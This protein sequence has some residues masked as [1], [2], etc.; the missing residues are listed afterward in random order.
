MAPLY[1]DFGD[2]RGDDFRAWWGGTAQ[3]GAALFAENRL[4]LSVKKIDA[5]SDWDSRWGSN[6]LVVALNMELGRRKLQSYL[7]KMLET[8]HTGKRGRKAMGKVEST[9]QFPLTRNFSVYNLK[10]MLMVYDTVAANETRPKSERK[11]LWKIG[12]E[13]KL[14]PSSM[15]HREDN[16]YDTRM[17]HNTLSMTV[18]RYANTARLIIANTAK[19]EFPNSQ[20]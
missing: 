10:R 2:V 13:L 7:A 11:A 12:E 3:R 9:A 8:E 4:D 19:G 18:S 5:A 1:A 20:K 6:V 14:V 15:P 16:K 17:K